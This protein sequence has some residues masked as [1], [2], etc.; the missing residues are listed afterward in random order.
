MSDDQHNQGE[1]SQES[2]EQVVLSPEQYSALLD[3]IEELGDKTSKSVY[4]LEELA[5]EGSGRY[6]DH[7]Q[8]QRPREPDID[9]EQMSNRQLVEYIF[10]VADDVLM[11]LDGKINQV[12]TKIETLKVMQEIDKLEKNPLTHHKVDPDNPE[13]MVSDFWDYKDAIY[14]VATENPTLSLMQVYKLVKSEKGEKVGVPGKREGRL[15]SLPPRPVFGE[16][17]GHSSSVTEKNPPKT[18][19]EA[20]EKAWKETVG[21][22]KEL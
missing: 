18:L 16:R 10:N 4:S 1:S 15:M 6:D 5:D 20:A 14:K 8:Q 13:R 12:D 9:V 3:R 7:P 2:E 22:K 11:K 21:N 19:Q 17:P